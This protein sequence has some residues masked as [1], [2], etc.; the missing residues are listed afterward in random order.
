MEECLCDVTFNSFYYYYIVI[1]II[2]IIIIH[3]S[4]CIHDF[5]TSTKLA[6]KARLSASP[7]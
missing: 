2:V 7:R 4:S 1:I 5:V 6:G 3:V